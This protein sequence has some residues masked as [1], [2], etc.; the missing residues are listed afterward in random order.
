MKTAQCGVAI[1]HRER[2]LYKQTLN[3]HR[4]CMQTTKFNSLSSIT[5]QR[6]M[7]PVKCCRSANYMPEINS[8]LNYNGKAFLFSSISRNPN[9]VIWNINTC[10]SRSSERYNCN[11]ASASFSTTSPTIVAV[12]EVVVLF[13][14][15]AGTF[16]LQVTRPSNLRSDEDRF[17]QQQSNT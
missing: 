14:M 17:A 3:V 6:T 15:W 7:A 9:Q 8:F 2:W 5:N 13:S 4:T 11:I 16:F 12:A 1:I 10:L